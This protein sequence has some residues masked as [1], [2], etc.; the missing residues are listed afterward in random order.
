M[1]QK[2]VENT[3][4]EEVVACLKAY[5]CIRLNGIWNTV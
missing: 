1:W 4:E 3:G 5:P 2:H